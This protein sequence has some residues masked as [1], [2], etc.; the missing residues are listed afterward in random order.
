VILYGKK[1]LGKVIDKESE[2]AAQLDSMLSQYGTLYVS[3]HYICFYSK[4]FGYESKVRN[5]LKQLSQL[6]HFAQTVV[7]L[8]TSKAITT[9]GDK[10]VCKGKKR[11]KK[12]K[13]EPK[14]TCF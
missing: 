12:S 2:F 4:I 14:I 3:E 10:M 6:T 5:I 7:P 8:S 1:F 13:S 9:K 11:V